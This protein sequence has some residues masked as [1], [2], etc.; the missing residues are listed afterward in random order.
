MVNQI[1]SLLALDDYIITDEERAEY[2]SPVALRFRALNN[3]MKILIP[4]FQENQSADQ[5][6]FNL[7]VD[8]YRIRRLFERNSPSIRIQAFYRGYKVR[9]NAFY[10]ASDRIR[11]AVRVQKIFR[12]W[13]CR[14]RARRELNKF[15][16][17]QNQ[18]ELLL[19][20]PQYRLFR[21]NKLLAEAM[22]RFAAKFRR[23]RLL[24]RSA[25]K[26]QNRWRAI[27]AKH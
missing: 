2:N 25:L 10:S 12:G 14:T 27:K 17:E 21:A 20:Q 4:K 11:A 13:L 1:R 5:H 22:R 8:L 3:H 23:E 6:L 19:S 24:Q 26:I 16:R 15:L 9:T 7:E 18:E